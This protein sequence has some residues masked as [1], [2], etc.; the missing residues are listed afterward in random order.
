MQIQISWLLQK[1]TDMDLHCLQRQGIY[2]GSAGLG[3]RGLNLVLWPTFILN[4]DTASATVNVLKFWTLYSIFFSLNFAFLC[5]CF[6]KY[7]VEWQSSLIWVCTVCIYHSVKHFGVQ[8]FRTFTMHITVPLHK[9]FLSH[10]WINT[11]KMKIV[12]KQRLFDTRCIK[13]KTF[14]YQNLSFKVPAWPWK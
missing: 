1:P 6:I 8:N 12:N 11:E 13:H 9:G 4:P 3:L 10:Q 2:P 14:F 7:L 5:S